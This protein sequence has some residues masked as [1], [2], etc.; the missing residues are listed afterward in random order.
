[1]SAGGWAIN[2][3][4]AANHC[5]VILK[6][7]LLIKGV[8]TISQL[9]VNWFLILQLLVFMPAKFNQKGS[10]S[11]TRLIVLQWFAYIN[12]YVH[13]FTVQAKKYLDLYILYLLIRAFGKWSQ[14]LV[15]NKHKYF[16]NKRKILLYL[17]LWFHILF[18]YPL[19]ENNSRIFF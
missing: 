6:P 19:L 15:T 18:L 12:F 16:I 13:L 9:T 11:P 7:I 2:S 10:E 5:T 14:S 8:M 3:F 17:R 4:I 1:M